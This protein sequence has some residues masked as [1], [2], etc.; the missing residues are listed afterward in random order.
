MRHQDITEA[1]NDHPRGREEHRLSTQFIIQTT[2]SLSRF[3]SVL[4]I[5]ILP[6]KTREHAFTVAKL[7]SQAADIFGAV[8]ASLDVSIRL[9]RAIHDAVGD[10]KDLPTVLASHRK[11]LYLT[12]AIVDSARAEP[13][14]QQHADITRAV[15]EIGVSTIAIQK[16]LDSLGGRSQFKE[17]AH[18]LFKGGKESK[19]LITLTDHLSR[20]KD[21]LMA[22]IGVLNVTIARRLE[23]RLQE[24]ADLYTSA[25]RRHTSRR[26]MNN[27]ASGRAFMINAP[28][29][30]GPS[31]KDPFEH[32]DEV[33]VDNNTATDDAIMLNYATTID[34]LNRLADEFVRKIRGQVEAAA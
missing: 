23:A 8:L 21:D 17:I 12:R 31:D 9:V 3:L 32:I 15:E 28:V 27:S 10:A 16:H 30:S 34:I 14:L 4:T 18:Q 24:V 22:L 7:L 20:R 1:F 5:F 25:E 19:T 26:I 33:V 2:S 11:E 13:E 6:A 29:V